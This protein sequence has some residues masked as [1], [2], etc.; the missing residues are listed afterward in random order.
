MAKDTCDG[1]KNISIHTLKRLK[2][3]DGYYNGYIKWTCRGEETGSCGLEVDLSD[4]FVR[5]TYTQTNRE[6]GNKRKFDYKTT[7]TSTP[8][9]FGGRRYW[10]ICPLTVR[11]QPCQRRVETLYLVGDWFG[12]RHCHDLAY[13]SQQQ[14]YT[15][16]IRYLKSYFDGDEVRK[17]NT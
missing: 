11:G 10:F 12:C 14:N 15:G 8:C 9:Y 17:K 5:F 16:F 3:L 4:S 6:T 13:D 2:M 1:Y 7:L